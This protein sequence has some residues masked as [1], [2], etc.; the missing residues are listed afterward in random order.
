MPNF[1][2][3]N[4]I[5]DISG[6][7][8]NEGILITV[9]RKNY[10][11]KY[12]AIIWQQTPDQLKKIL[13]ENLTFAE[14]HWLPLLLSKEKV[15]YNTPVPLLEPFLFKNQ[16]YDLLYCET[17]DKVSQLSYLKKF[18]NLEF[19]FSRE[20]ATLPNLSLTYENSNTAVIPFTFGKESLAT[21]ALCLEL[22]IKSILVYCQEPAHP[23][24]ERYKLHELKRIEKKYKIKTYFIRHDPGLFRYGKAFNLEKETDIGWG[25]QITLL[26]ILSLPFVYYHKARYILFGNE[27]SNNEMTKKNGWKIFSSIDQTGNIVPQQSSLI[28]LLTSGQCEVKSSLDPLEEFNIFYLLHHR[29]PELG[30][31]Q[32]SCSAEK[33]LKGGRQWC[34]DCYKCARM[35]L[36]A[37]ALG[38][39]VADLGFKKDLLA[40]LRWWNHYFGKEIKTGPVSELDFAFYLLYLKGDKSVCVKKFRKDKLPRLKN[41]SWHFKNYTTIK[42][43]INLPEKYNMKMIEIFQDEMKNFKKLISQYGK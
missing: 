5:L 40:D 8:I 37:K 18:Y 22:G 2:K 20:E 26:A 38:F 9:K 30:R 27:Y 34:H 10:Q 35:Y 19:I 31:Y 24:E 11:I 39:S 7:L 6:K 14:T 17:V 21:L 42:P 23:Y 15:F 25:T 4:R 43:T 32:F 3:N 12:P 28:R 36:F 41:W 16:L 29:Y 33:P 13:L 1:E